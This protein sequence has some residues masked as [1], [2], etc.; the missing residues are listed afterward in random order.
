MLKL[1]SVICLLCFFLFACSDTAEET[2]PTNSTQA[3]ISLPSIQCGSCASTVK[4]ILSELEGVNNAT[5]NLKAKTVSL[6]FNESQIQLS[7]METAIAAAGYHANE[8]QRVS[9]AYAE[10]DACCQEQ[11]NGE[12]DAHE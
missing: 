11:Q 7:A 12:E 1:N 2:I 8:T 10:L 4:E 5:V 9:A 3:D 6:D